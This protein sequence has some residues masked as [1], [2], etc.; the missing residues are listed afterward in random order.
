MGSLATLPRGLSRLS[1]KRQA[2]TPGGIVRPRPSRRAS[3]LL[4]A[5]GA[6]AASWSGPHPTRGVPGTDDLPDA[7]LDVRWR[8]RTKITVSGTRIVGNRGF[9]DFPVLLQLGPDETTVFDKTQPGG[10]D[11]VVT[12]GDGVTVL[13]RQIASWNE[14]RHDAEV[15]FRAP[16]LSKAERQFYLYYGNPDTTLAAADGSVWS[17][18]YLGVYHFAEDPGAGVLRDHGSWGHDAHAGVNA[19][20][21]SNDTIGGAVGQAWRFNGTTHWIDGDAL[22]SADSSFTISAWFACW[23]QLRPEDADFAFSAEEGFWHLSAKR[24]SQQRV[25]DFAG[26]GAYTWGPSPLPDTLLHHYVWAMDG[27]ADTIRFY[28]DG[29][30]QPPVL[31]GG[32]G[33]RAYRGRQILGEVGIASPLFGNH[34]D[35]MEGIVDEFRVQT[36]VLSPEWIETEYKNMSDP[37]GFVVFG[38][39]DDVTPVH[40][41]SFT[42][43]RGTEGAVLRWTVQSQVPD[44][45]GFHVHR[46]DDGVPRQRL[47]TTL[48][49][50]DLDY[51]F[52]DPQPPPTASEYW[53][54]EWLTTGAIVWHGPALLAGARRLELFLA[55]NTP[56]PFT[57]STRFD[58][59]LA[60]PGPVRLDVY[61]VA[62]RLVARLVAGSLPAGEHGIAWNGRDDQGAFVP[63]G[64]YF[65][66]LE[67][68]GAAVTRKLLLNR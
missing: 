47:T 55:P 2:A 13:S 30:E 1:G 29:V 68:G 33:G 40:L 20:Y 37:A 10:G 26:G 5:L 24:N 56:N 60:E 49:V 22:Q 48:L 4:L 38:P 25:P 52:V 57:A 16:V 3:F 53:L 6:A 36:G 19:Q 32:P 14:T 34:F 59:H 42:A 50:G 43:A 51:V 58:F 46:G 44:L 63:S 8:Y 7:W 21:T 62:G 9:D 45:L 18:A 23:N 66:K 65:C 67:S 54:A 61:D 27:V 11:L 35:L 15:W 64:V 28:Y 39:E 31:H 12:A 41:L 17:P